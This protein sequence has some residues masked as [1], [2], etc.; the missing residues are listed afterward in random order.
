MMAYCGDVFRDRTVLVTPAISRG[1]NHNGYPWEPD[2]WTQEHRQ[3]QGEN[4]DFLLV[5]R[6][7]QSNPKA[8]LNL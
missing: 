4:L 2:D 5:A 7:G 3:D 8:H 6:N 1:E